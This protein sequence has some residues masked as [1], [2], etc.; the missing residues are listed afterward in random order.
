MMRPEDA[1]LAGQ[2]GADAIGLVFH[3]PARRNIS[4]EQAREILTALPAFVTPVALFVNAPSGHI[5]AIVQALKIRHVQ[6]HG[7][8]TPEQLAELRGLTLLKALRVDSTAF[9]AEL[10]AWRE[11]IAR[12]QLTHLRA[13]VLETPTQQAGGT[14]AEND[15]AMIQRHQ[16]QGDFAGLPPL[17]VAGGLTPE[18]VT[19]VIRALRPYAVDVSSGIEQRL[20]EKSAQ[21]MERFVAA[22]G[23]A[24]AEGT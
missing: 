5:W 12:L 4:I 11:A 9:G 7:Q 14:G 22:V 8:E 10:R 17:V 18:N 20:G 2:L 1:A 21:K 16:Q 24:D 19:P 6:L 3:P 23:Q 13:L 15:W